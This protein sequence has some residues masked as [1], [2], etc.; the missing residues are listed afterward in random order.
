MYKEVV[1]KY[2]K[3]LPEL[4][5][6]IEFYCG[7]YKTILRDDLSD[8]KVDFLFLDGAENAN[9]TFEQFRYFPLCLN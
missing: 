3:Y 6:Y 9:Q 2:N 1:N 7:D 8:F 5:K 4:L